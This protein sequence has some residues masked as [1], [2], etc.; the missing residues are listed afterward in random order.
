MRVHIEFYAPDDLDMELNQEQAL[1][2]E[3]W[4]E[5]GGVTWSSEW[6]QFFESIEHDVRDHAGDYRNI[7]SV[8]RA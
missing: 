2:Y 1:L 5:S 7:D 4:V 8:E 6:L 3:R